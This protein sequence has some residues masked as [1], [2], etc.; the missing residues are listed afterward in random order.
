MLI[1]NYS[2]TVEAPITYGKIIDSSLKY[3]NE[4]RMRFTFR[5]FFYPSKHKWVFRFYTVFLHWI[6]AVFIDT[7]LYCTG[8]KPRF[9]KTNLK[10]KYNL[11]F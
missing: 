6:P 7:I 1:Y 9:F 8:G 2:S 10:K 5:Y 11:R 3:M 4:C